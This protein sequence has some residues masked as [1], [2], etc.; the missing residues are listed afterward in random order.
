MGEEH[1]EEN[2]VSLARAKEHFLLRCKIKKEE[3]DSD[4]KRMVCEGIIDGKPIS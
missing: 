4:Y 2:R 1:P 3:H